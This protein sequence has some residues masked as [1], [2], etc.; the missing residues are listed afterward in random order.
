[1]SAS[2]QQR[3]FHK[4]LFRELIPRQIDRRKFA[5]CRTRSLPSETSDRRAFG[6]LTLIRCSTGR[7]AAVH[8][9]SYAGDVGCLIR[10]KPER[11]ICNFGGLAHAGHGNSGDGTGLSLLGNFLAGIWIEEQRQYGRFNGP[12]QTAFSGTCPLVM[13]YGLSRAGQTRRTR[14]LR[15]NSAASWSAP[16]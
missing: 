16:Y 8:R 14:R 13:R 1:M 9:Q 6:L 11:G 5:A 7:E 3:P 12:G 15:P 10:R 4:C 2:R